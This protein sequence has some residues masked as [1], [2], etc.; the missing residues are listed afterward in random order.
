MELYMEDRKKLLALTIFHEKTLIPST[1]SGILKPKPIL[2]DKQASE[3]CSPEPKN[4][5]MMQRGF[6]DLGN[7][8]KKKVTLR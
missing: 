8:I 3:P 7:R 2:I 4:F 6:S 5:P 1:S